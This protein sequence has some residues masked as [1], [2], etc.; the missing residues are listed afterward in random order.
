MDMYEN[1]AQTLIDRLWVIEDEAAR[2]K[3]EKQDLQAKLSRL[4]TFKPG[5]KTGHVVTDSHKVTVTRRETT[6]YDQA[7]LEAAR[8]AIG[9]KA[10]L[11]AFKWEFKPLSKRDFDFWMATATDEQKAF[12]LRAMTTKPAAPSVKIKEL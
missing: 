4:A 9:D 10:F 8:Q 2:L 11:S 12:V 3:A 5:S 6:R 7:K 1:E